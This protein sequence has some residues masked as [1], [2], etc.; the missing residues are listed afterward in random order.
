M[1]TKKTVCIFGPVDMISLCHAF[2]VVF[3]VLK[4]Y[5]VLSLFLRVIL[6]QYEIESLAAVSMDIVCLICDTV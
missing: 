1:C 3:T 4:L 5:C 2:R 6:L